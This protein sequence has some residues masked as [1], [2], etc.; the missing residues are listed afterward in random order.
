[1]N[2]YT[3]AKQLTSNTGKK[4]Y[5][6]VF[7][8]EIPTTDNDIYII[9]ES[10]DR[11]DLIAHDYYADVKY[12]VVIAAVNNLGKGTYI[13]PAGLQLRLPADLGKVESMYNE[14]QKNR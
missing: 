12:W 14:F 11:L 8:P 4:Y 3:P 10:G 1:M 9:T 13:V 7:F 2:R 6:S 5:E